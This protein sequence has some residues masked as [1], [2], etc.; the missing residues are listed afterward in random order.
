MSEMA[1]FIKELDG[2]AL[3]PRIDLN[4]IARSPPWLSLISLS[5]ISLET[6]GFYSPSRRVNAMASL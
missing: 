2:A 3:H 5:F 6:L 1:P 4:N